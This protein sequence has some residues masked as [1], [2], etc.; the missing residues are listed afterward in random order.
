MRLLA[1]LRLDLQA[2]SDLYHRKGINSTD[3][4]KMNFNTLTPFV[5]SSSILLA[6]FTPSHLSFIHLSPSFSFCFY[7]FLYSLNFHGCPPSPI[8]TELL[9][10]NPSSFILISFF[11][12]LYFPLPSSSSFLIS[13]FHFLPSSFYFLTIFYLLIILFLL[14]NIFFPLLTI[15]FLLLTIFFFLIIFFLLL[16]IF[17]LLLTIFYLLIIFFLL[18]IIF[19]SLSI[20]SFRFFFLLLSLIFST[21]L[22]W[23]V[24]Q[25]SDNPP[26]VYILAS[27]PTM[28]PFNF[29]A[30]WSCLALQDSPLFFSLFPPYIS[31]SLALTSLPPPKKKKKNY[32]L[33]FSLISFCIRMFVVFWWLAWECCTFWENDNN[34]FKSTN[35]RPILWLYCEQLIYAMCYIKKKKPK[36]S[37]PNC[38]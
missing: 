1:C 18:L 3:C 15:F 20:S 9:F 21:L 23:S 8:F 37:W 24:P 13:S 29:I 4:V 6:S 32:W 26:Y 36:P 17:F 12:S 30:I 11:S 5:S 35:T 34:L 19:L 27:D 38:M 10:I 22:F 33:C 31:S 14:L 2:S 16:I 7:Q 25:P 28:I